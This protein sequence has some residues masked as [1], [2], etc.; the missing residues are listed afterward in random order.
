MVYRKSSTPK[1]VLGKFPE[2]RSVLI[3]LLDVEVDTSL[4]HVLPLLNIL[5]P[6]DSYTIEKVY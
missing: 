6:N 3:V 1:P 4:P 2:T 5:S